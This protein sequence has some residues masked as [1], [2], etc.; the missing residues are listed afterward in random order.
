M[1][2]N[3]AWAHGIFLFRSPAVHGWV[4]VATQKHA[5]PL[6]GLKPQENYVFAKSPRRERLG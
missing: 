5:L 4:N 2:E 6:Q 3:P 1:G